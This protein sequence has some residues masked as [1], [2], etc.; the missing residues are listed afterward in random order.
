MTAHPMDVEVIVA[1]KAESMD[2]I[3]MQVAPSDMRY[4]IVRAYTPEYDEALRHARCVIGWGDMT[5]RPDFFSKAPNLQLIQLLSAGY[6]GCDIEGA[7]RAGALI[8]LNGGANSQAVA[9]HV[10]MLMLA[11]SRRLI[12]QHNNVL[13]GQWWG[14]T[15]LTSL[16]L[17]ELGGRTL[18][19][20]GFGNIGQKIAAIARAFGMRIVYSDLVRA[21]LDQE[22][23][24]GAEFVGFDELLKLSDFLSLNVPLTDRTRGLI[25][26][27]ELAAMKPT[28]VLIN[29]GR[30][31]LVDEAALCQA[32]REGRFGGAGLDVF[33][34]EP[35]DTSN[36]LLT[37]PQVVASPHL[38]GPTQDS[39]YRRIG[40]GFDN[41]R[42][43]LN[44][45]PVLWVI[46]ELQRE[47]E[48]Q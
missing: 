48:V 29:T 6:D 32:I 18:G 14:T 17:F 47:A 22:K 39:W 34:Q 11:V 27:R 41:A 25:G 13:N 21:P 1:S 20:L 28:A 43:L 10:I 36:P 31:A 19:I 33:Q 44:G 26:A 40:N 30:G 16:P 46:P 5:G 42:R 35:A 15:D 12:W 3:A 37:L 9:E 38:A 4:R 7:R 23:A 45:Q 8:A 24:A 2:R